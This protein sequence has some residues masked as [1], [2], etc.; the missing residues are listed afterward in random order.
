MTWG[1][2]WFDVDGGGAGGAGDGG[3][4]DVGGLGCGRAM[5]QCQP[6][7][8]A[9]QKRGK[10]GCEP[11]PWT[12]WAP[13]WPSFWLPGPPCWGPWRPRA[14]QP[15][16]RSD[17]CEASPHSRCGDR[18]PTRSGQLWA[19][20]QPGACR[21]NGSSSARAAA[22]C[23]TATDAAGRPAT[24]RSLAEPGAASEAGR[25]ATGRF[26]LLQPAAA[27]VTC[28]AASW[29]RCGFETKGQLGPDEHRRACVGEADALVSATLL[30]AVLLAVR[31]GVLAVGLRLCGSKR[32]SVSASP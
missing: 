14:T 15:R 23:R 16:R 32:C 2:S 17:A 6:S 10:Q 8:S 5:R 7:C 25:P 27:A 30:V 31:P 4:G 18:S 28:D 29:R 11:L 1:E 21:P 19:A 12:S 26:A 13:L 20:H 22:T 24:G 9:K 3:A